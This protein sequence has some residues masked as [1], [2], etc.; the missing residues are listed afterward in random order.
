MNNQSPR[1][2]GST[3]GHRVIHHDREEVDRRLWND[4]FSEYPKY[5]EAMFRRRFRMSQNL[6]LR[7]ANV[8]KGHDNYF[9]QR[10][11]RIDRLAYLLY[12]KVTMAFQILVY[13]IPADAVDK[14]IH[15]GETTTIESLKRSC[16]AIVEIFGERYL[17]AHDANDVA[18]LLQIGEKRGFP[19]MFGS[20]DCM[21]WIWKICPTAW[22]GQ[23]A[24]RSRESPIIPEAVANYDDRL[25]TSGSCSR[26]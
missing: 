7:I 5:S 23:Y 14:Y 9:V 15:I 19:G 12:K 16:R 22:A 4:Y 21:P 10:N 6:F 11:D 24:R 17:R 2:G 18:R 26:L 13:G 8:V 20:L 25:Y 3:F 1:H